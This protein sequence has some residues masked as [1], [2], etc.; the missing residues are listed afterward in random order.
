MRWRRLLGNRFVLVP[1]SILAM[2]LAWNGYVS[3]NNGGLIRGRVVD[4]A[5]QPVE[6][7]TVTLS[8]LTVTAFA[9]KARAETDAAGGFRFEQNPSHHVQLQADSPMGRSERLVVR[10]WFRGQNI[11]L[12]EPLTLRPRS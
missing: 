8:V 12:P 11:E 4:A 9:E 1:A 2:A 7:A 6:G 5:G 3:F 10:L